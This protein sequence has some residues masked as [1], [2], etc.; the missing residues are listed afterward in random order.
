M[1]KPI[2]KYPLRF[3]RWF[4]KKDYLEEIEGNLI[5][6]FEMDAAEA[7]KRARLNFFWNVLLHFRPEYIRE[8]E[9]F[10]PLIHYS[11]LQNYLI[12]AWRNLLKQKVYALINIGGLAIGLAS[13]I[14]I[15]LFVDSFC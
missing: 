10:S 3:L 12:V 15:F 2:P 11:M 6:L 13:F 1:D 5:E 8:F 14:L 7:G 9:R 4:C